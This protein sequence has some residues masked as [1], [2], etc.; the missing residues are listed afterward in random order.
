MPCIRALLA[1]VEPGT[2]VDV[3]ERLAVPFPLL[4]IADLLGVDGDDWPRFRV[5]TDL[6]IEAAQGTTPESEAALGEMAM[7][8]LDLVAERLD[9]DGERGRGREDVDDPAAPRELTAAGDLELRQVAEGEE[10]AGEGVGGDP[11]TRAEEARLARGRATLPG[12]VGWR[13]RIRTWNPLIQR[14]HARI[15]PPDS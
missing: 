14:F 9:A 15:V 11:G 12:G 4:V 7:Y 13:A 6:M 5:W 8:F 10:L 1:A 2:I 3:V